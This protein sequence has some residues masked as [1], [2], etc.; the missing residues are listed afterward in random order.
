[1]RW[2]PQTGGALTIEALG[3]LTDSFRP[4]PENYG[5]DSMWY[6]T[7][8]YGIDVKRRRNGS[9]GKEAGWEWLYV[10]AEMTESRNGRFGID[11]LV[12]DEEGEIVATSRHVALIVSA[13]R[14]TNGRTGGVA[15]I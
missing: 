1:M 11:V 12:V 2:K 10:K 3:F 6:P 14:N 4:V 7:L 5:L 9:D 8:N 15:K 13:E